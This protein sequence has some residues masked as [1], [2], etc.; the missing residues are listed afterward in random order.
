MT[1]PVQIR[2]VSIPVQIHVART[3]NVESTITVPFVIVW[4]VTQAILSLD[5]IPNHV[6]FSLSQNSRLVTYIDL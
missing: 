6:R 5:V 4:M 2:N 3:P 1:K